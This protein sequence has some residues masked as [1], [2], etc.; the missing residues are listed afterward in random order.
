MLVSPYSDFSTDDSKIIN[1][2]IGSTANT[3]SV[4]KAWLADQY[5][6]G[7][8]VWIDFNKNGCFQ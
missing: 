1:L 8:G 4:T 7:V 6:E 2:V 5:S 3:I